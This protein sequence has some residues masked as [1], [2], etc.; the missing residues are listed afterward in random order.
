MLH[1]FS[2]NILEYYSNLTSK[3]MGYLRLYYTPV[4]HLYTIYQSSVVFAIITYK[5]FYI[6]VLLNT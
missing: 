3:N 4:L 5:T 1:M 2:L 6:D